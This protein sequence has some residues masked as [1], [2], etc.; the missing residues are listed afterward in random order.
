MCFDFRS[1]CCNGPSNA[2]EVR[3]SVLAITPASSSAAQSACQ[4][5]VAHLTLIGYSR[6]PEKTA[7][8]PNPSVSGGALGDDV[9]S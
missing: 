4:A 9:T 2:Y 5:S 1:C 7:S 6:T 3:Y 8:F